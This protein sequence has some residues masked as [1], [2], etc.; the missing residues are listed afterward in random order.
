MNQ[1][2]ICAH[3]GEYL[4]AEDGVYFE[5]QFFC[6]DC[7][8]ELTVFCHH[9]GERIWR[10]ANNGTDNIPLCDRCYDAHYTRCDRLLHQ[11]D[12]Y[13][14]EDDAL[15]WSCYEASQRDRETIVR[16]QLK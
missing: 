13:Y 3:C 6:P 1:K 15:C 5:D 9:C 7:L 12:V 16:A 11:G 8:E 2:E 14:D 10:E 4:S